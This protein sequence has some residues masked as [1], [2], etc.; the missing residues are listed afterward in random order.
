ML[1]LS[2]YFRLILFIPA[3]LCG[4]QLPG[5]V[6]QYGKSLSSHLNEAAAS[7]NEFQDDADKYFN[8]SLEKLIQHYSASNDQVF[9]DGG[10]SI[11]A[12]YQRHALLKSA[13][14]RFGENEYGP[15]YQ[16]FI[17]PIPDI[18]QEVWQAF[19]HTVVQDSSSI[20]IGVLCGIHVALLFGGCFGLL[21]IIGRQFGIGSRR[22]RNIRIGRG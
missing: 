2:E 13:L 12:I 16:S 9:N 11:Q 14:T 1:K 15:Y 5:F 6:D 22:I 17:E 19:T 20:V 21:K 10:Q 4:L 18:Q 7:L 8:G 3:M